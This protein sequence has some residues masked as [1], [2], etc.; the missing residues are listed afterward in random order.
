MLADVGPAVRD[1]PL[2]HELTIGSIRHF[3][4]LSD[5]IGLR[6]R[7]PLKERDAIIQSLLLIGAYQIRHT[8]IPQYAAVNETVAGTRQIGRPW[9]RGLVNHVLRHL[10]AGPSSAPSTEPAQF[11]H[12]SWMIERLRA[13]YPDAWR[14]ILAASLTRAPLTLRVNTAI[15][16]RQRFQELLAQRGVIT[17][18]GEPEECLLLDSPMPVAELPGCSDGSFAVQDAGAM[19]AATLLGATGDERVLDACAAPGGKAT[20]LVQRAP[21]IE[22]TALEIDGER[23][24]TLRSEFRRMGIDPASVRQGDG[25]ALDWWNGQP[26]QRVLVDA[27]CSGTGTLRRHPDIK[28]L[29]RESDLPRFQELQRR[30]L[31]NLWGVLSSNGRLLYCTC[32]VLSVENDGVIDQ[33]VSIARDAH[34]VPIIA[35][36]GIATQHGRQLL[37]TAGGP[38]GFYYAMIEKR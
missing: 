22:L 32:S 7:E 5:E 33:F 3:F 16:G 23:C 26:F 36:W 29:K 24:E 25:T 13:D 4:S 38:D 34:P 14:Q 10:A 31:D 18:F 37:P 30:L 1:A 2:I 20:H 11:D 12:P 19:W 9:A 21:G 35:D 8:R 6:L 17:H 27:P 28:L 15:T